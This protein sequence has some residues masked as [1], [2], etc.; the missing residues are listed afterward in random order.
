MSSPRQID[1]NRGNGRLS[2]GPK[3]GEGKAASSKNAVKH[4]LL[5]RDILLPEE[6][7]EAFDDLAEGIRADLRPEGRLETELIER[8]TVLAWR[9]RRIGKA[10][11]AILAWHQ[12]GVLGM[13]EACNKEAEMDAEDALRDANYL[14]EANDLGKTTEIDDFML[15]KM[16][17]LVVTKRHII[18]RSEWLKKQAL[19]APLRLGWDFRKAMIR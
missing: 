1:A 3:T 10:E 2:N 16:P 17:P 19:V 15:P 6:V 7:A 14:R 8:I 18:M 4:G 11:R 5:S 9:L 13:D 12:F